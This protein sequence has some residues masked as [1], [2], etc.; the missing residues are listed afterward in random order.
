MIRGPNLLLKH[1]TQDKTSAFNRPMWPCQLSWH[2]QQVSWALGVLVPKLRHLPQQ[3]IMHPKLPRVTHPLWVV[4]AWIHAHT[5]LQL[6]LIHYHQPTVHF[7]N[8]LLQ[9]TSYTPTSSAQQLIGLCQTC[10]L[11]TWCKHPGHT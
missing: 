11:H 4:K 5:L 2:V 7:S 6:L 1:A 9:P 10:N 3:P 8:K